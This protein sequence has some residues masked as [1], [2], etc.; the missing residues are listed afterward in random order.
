MKMIHVFVCSIFHI[1]SGGAGD[2]LKLMLIF[3]LM[4]FIGRFCETPLKNLYSVYPGDVYTRLCWS[5]SGL[6][7]LSGL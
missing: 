1:T 5:P 6:V 2:R 3:K 4:F 7:L